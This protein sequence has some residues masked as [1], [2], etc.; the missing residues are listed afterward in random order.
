GALVELIDRALVGL[1]ESP[2]GARLMARRAAALGDEKAGREA[3]AL[4][5][6]VAAGRDLGAV[7]VS[8]FR[9]LWSPDNLEERFAWAAEILELAQAAGDLE[10]ELQGRHALT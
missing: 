6:R 8:L 9:T 2:L 4:A 3:L 1:A 5:R 7:L 10:L